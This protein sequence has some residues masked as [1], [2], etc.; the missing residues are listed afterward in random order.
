MAN[1]LPFVLGGV[2]LLAL[3]GG[4]K[5]GGSA[6][7]ATPGGGLKNVRAW[8]EWVEAAGTLYGFSRFAPAVAYT[9]SGGNN[10]IGLGISQGILP[11]NVKLR[12]KGKAAKGEAEAACTLWKGARSRGWYQD[13]PY[14]R[15]YWCFG[16]GGWFGFL[17]ATGL[18]AG[19]QNGPFVE[20]SPFMVFEPIESVVML[21]DFVK[22]TVRGNR[23][24]SLPYGEQNWLAIRRGLAGSF[25]IDDYQEEHER[26]PKTRAR[27][28]KA[29][30]ETGTDPDFMWER[31]TVGDWPGATAL[32]QWLYD[33]RAAA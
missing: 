3:A 31:P 7:P 16:S 22:R 4:R 21:A 32:L 27:L 15:R 28:E 20:Q 12:S 17:P 1:V 2:A 14:D 9:E 29:L 24:Q 23:F 18:S 6:P 11:S 30:A 13:N 8:G 5:G 26:S 25:L 19:G 33:H 10:L